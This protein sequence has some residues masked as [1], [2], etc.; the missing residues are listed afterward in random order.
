MGIADLSVEELKIIGL[1]IRAMVDG[2]FLDS[3]EFNIRVGL[4]KDR[5]AEL[6]HNWPNLDD[7]LDSDDVTLMI[8]NCLNEVSFG[9]EMTEQQCTSLTG[10]TR[11]DVRHVYEKWALSKGWNWTG[12]S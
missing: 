7:S 12:I 8:N 1:S 10:V 9:P 11:D 2:P 3:D 6:M 4:P 5:T